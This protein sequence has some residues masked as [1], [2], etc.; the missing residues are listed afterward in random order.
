MTVLS[1]LTVVK[2]AKDINSFSTRLAAK[3][4]QN[5]LGSSLVPF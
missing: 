1:T 4:L 3:Q 2:S 5:K